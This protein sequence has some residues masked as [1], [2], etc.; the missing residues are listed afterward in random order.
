MQRYEIRL[1]GTRSGR[2][3]I[4]DQKTMAQV[5]LFSTPRP[6]VTFY[7]VVLFQQLLLYFSISNQA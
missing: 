2:K 1:T 6:F 7:S 5:Q 4:E 3:Q